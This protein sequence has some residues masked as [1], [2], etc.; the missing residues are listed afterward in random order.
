MRTI[1]T[2]S[3]PAYLVHIANHLIQF[4][5]T[6]DIQLLLTNVIEKTELN[7]RLRFYI[8]N[9]LFCKGIGIRQSEKVIRKID[10]E[11]CLSQWDTDSCCLSPSVQLNYAT[12]VAMGKG[13]ESAI[14]LIQKIYSTNP[15][16]QNAFAQVAWHRYITEDTAYDKVIP[17]FEKDENEG[18]LCGVWRC[19]YA[20]AL[21][22]VGREAEAKEIIEDTYTKENSLSGG[23]AKCGLKYLLFFNDLEKAIPWFERELSVGQ[24]SNAHLINYTSILAVNGFIDEATSLA[25][26][27]QQENPHVNGYAYLAWYGHL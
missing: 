27:I 24:L 14:P 13:M 7:W 3:N 20:Q 1:S 16:I 2:T 5:N 6:E 19:N 18:K 17:Y 4:G 23:F 22:F 15:G 12:V 8:A 10:I 9:A 11:Q 21:M 26:R 25:Q